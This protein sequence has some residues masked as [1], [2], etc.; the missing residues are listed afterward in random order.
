MPLYSYKKAQVTLKQGSYIIHHPD[1]LT[2]NQAR[3]KMTVGDAL[4]GAYN[5]FHKLMSTSKIAAMFIPALLIGAGVFII[6]KQVW[7]TIVQTAQEAS[8]YFDDKG[9][10]LVAGQYVTAQQTYSDP[11]SKYFADL[12][13]T[14][15]HENLLFNDKKSA[16]YKGN[17][18]LSIPSLGLKDL[19]VVSNVDSS[20]EEVY[21]DLLNGGLAHFQ[22]TPLPLTDGPNYNIVIY[23][24]SSAGD[25]YERTKDP[26]SSFSILNQIRYGSDIIVNF[27]GKE[28]KYRF[29][30]GKIVNAN[31]LTILQGPKNQKTLTLF[32]CYPNGNNSK[33]FVATAKLV[34][35]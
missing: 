31:D 7:P 35:E 6:Y 5:D 14:A 18:S 33:R 25:Y 17:F 2:V 29:T 23:G 16:E 22:G 20:I 9:K 19:K 13:T 27:E 10:S 8:G 24:H 34:E 1:T 3:R 32:T 12:K 30:K 21:D 4:S 26:T 28:Y 15:Q 11:G